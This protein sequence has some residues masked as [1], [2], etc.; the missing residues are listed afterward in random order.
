M[1]HAARRRSSAD[2]QNAC[3]EYFPL[4]QPVRLRSST[5]LSSRRSGFSPRPASVSVHQHSVVLGADG[6]PFRAV[7]QNVP[8]RHR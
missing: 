4:R 6:F 1:L 2:A 7:P 8:S 5:F 3:R